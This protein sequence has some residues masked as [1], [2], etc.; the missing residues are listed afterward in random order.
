VKQATFATEQ[1]IELEPPSQVAW[2]AVVP[3][4]VVF[5]VCALR[6]DEFVMLNG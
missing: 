6:S 5:P 3:I 4:P 2:I 1:V